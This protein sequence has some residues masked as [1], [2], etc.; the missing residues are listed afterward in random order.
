[1][2]NLIGLSILFFGL[3][4]CDSEE[5]N[6]SINSE[7]IGK[8]KLTEAYISAGG[9]QYWVDVEN[10]EEF[11]FFENG[12]FNSNRFSECTTGTFSTEQNEL[13]LRYNCN[14]FESGSENED[15]YI[16]YDL[17]FEFDY[18][19]ITPSSGPICI[20]GCSYKYRKK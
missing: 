4:S 1:M 10:G 3:F 7:L 19:I 17:N 6:E 12:L 18:F 5:T 2:R 14:G 11:M 16:T 13:L 8:W 15:G 9:P 20:E